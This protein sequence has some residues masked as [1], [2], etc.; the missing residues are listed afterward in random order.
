MSDLIEKV[1]DALDELK[2]AVEEFEEGHASNEFTEGV[3]AVVN[4]LTT[5]EPA[6]VA[7]FM[8]EYGLDGQ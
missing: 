4:F 3:M 1:M 8:K 2:E 7:G 5:G 6:D